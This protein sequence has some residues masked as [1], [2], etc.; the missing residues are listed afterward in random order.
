[1][2]ESLLRT[3]FV[4]RDGF[5][6]W[7]GQIPP[8]DSWIGQANGGGWGN[9]YKVRIMG[10]HP[11][12]TNELADEDLPWAGV[13]LPPGNTGS[14]GVSKSV[15]FQPGDTVIGFFLDGENAQIPMIFGCFGNSQY[16][17]KDGEELPFGAFTGYTDK[18][19]RPSPTSVSP[20]E[21]NDPSAASKPSPRHVSPKDAKKIDKDNPAAMASAEG[22]VIKLPTEDKDAISKIQAAV[23]DFSDFVSNVKAQFDAGIDFVKEWIDNEIVQRVEKIVAVATGLVGG[24]VNGFFESMIPILKKGLEMLYK[25]VYS[26]VLS[27]TGLP[28]VAHLAGVAA[29]KAMGIPIK[30]LQDFIPCVVNK[31]L[32]Q[33]GDLASNVLRSVADNVTNFV[34]CVADQSVG[35]LLNGIIGFVDGA[36]GPL[37]GGIQKILQFIGGFSVEGLLR[38]GIAAISGIVGFASCNK[39]SKS[40]DAPLKYMIG[41]GPVDGGTPNLNKIMESANVAKGMLAAGQEGFSLLSGTISQL[42]NVGE[43]I[44]EC[45]AGPPLTCFAPKLSIFGGGGI[46]AA[47]EVI[48]GGVTPIGTAGIIGVKITSGGSGYSSPPFIQIQDNCKQGYGAVARATIKDG[49]VNNIYIVSEGENYPA[50]EIV[51]QVVTDV[52]VINPGSDYSS[53][54]VVVDDLGNEYET[55]VF[56]GAIVKVTPIN[57]NDITDLPRLTVRT[58]TGSGAKLYPTLGERPTGELQ[59]VIDCIT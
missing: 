42:S 38:E 56:N 41:F 2:E 3:N 43:A 22:S 51:P 29:Q 13:I 55:T 31:V 7:I 36:L 16:A 52:S 48:M 44:G 9:R 14:A 39:K 24:M 45:Y 23:E 37:I 11:Y 20:N 46:G 58:T 50:G 47:A 6:W 17:V 49:V 15:K 10:Y 57:T 18:I 35:A 5:I 19:K 27:A 53:D 26:L 28:P 4:G 40:S 34:E 30:L 12:N 32:G 8:V 25:S 1:M 54:D 33:I 21:S 59:Q